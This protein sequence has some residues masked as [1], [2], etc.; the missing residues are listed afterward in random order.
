MFDIEMRF[1]TSSIASD[2]MRLNASEIEFAR[3]ARFRTI[4]PMLSAM[5]LT[6]R[7]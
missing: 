7:P 6:G 3:S 4:R 5:P 2:S 1:P